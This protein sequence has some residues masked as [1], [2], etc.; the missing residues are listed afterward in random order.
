MMVAQLSKTIVGKDNHSSSTHQRT[1]QTKND[2]SNVIY[3]GVQEVETS[4]TDQVTLETYWPNGLGVE[5]DRPSSATELNWTHL[6]H[7]GSPVALSDASGIL[8]ERLAF[9]SWGKRRTIDGVPINGTAPPD[10]LDGQT[11]NKG[12]TGHEM[13]DQLD[14]VHMNGR[15]YD[16]L[17]GRFLSG[18][19][20][21]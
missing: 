21:I 1:R 5:I 11:D 2:C 14:L 7:L 4:S 13:L 8:K 16:P 20:L 18:D 10:S 17:T 6:D 19:P 9:D 12:Y 3:A 15:V